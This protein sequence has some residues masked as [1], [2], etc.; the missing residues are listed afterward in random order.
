MRQYMRQ[1][2]GDRVLETVLSLSRKRFVGTEVFVGNQETIRIMSKQP[3]SYTGHIVRSF[4]AGERIGIRTRLFC[5]CARLSGLA[6]TYAS[7]EGAMSWGFMV[8]GE[9][10]RDI[11]GGLDKFSS[12]FR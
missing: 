1:V 6:R 3:D 12:I 4:I 9:Y 5:F 10:P 2:I 8:Y 11:P 7:R